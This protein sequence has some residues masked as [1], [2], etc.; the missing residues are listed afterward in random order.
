M[1]RIA[2]RALRKSPPPSRAES[3]AV[4]QLRDSLRPESRL[5][6]CGAVVPEDADANMRRSARLFFQLVP[7]RYECASLLITTNQAGHAMGHRLRQRR[8]RSCDPRSAAAS[9]PHTDDSRG[10]L[11]IA[12][13]EEGHA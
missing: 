5:G 2:I 1:S 4:W 3:K 11:S 8:P 9:Q 13:E 7:R 6:E 12:A 10:E